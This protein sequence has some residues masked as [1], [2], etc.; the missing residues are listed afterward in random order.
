M[1]VD[2]DVYKLSNADIYSSLCR[3]RI[4][5]GET[6]LIKNTPYNKY[7][8]CRFSFHICRAAEVCKKKVVKFL[9]ELQEVMFL[10][11]IF[12]FRE[13]DFNEKQI[14]GSQHSESR[15]MLWLPLAQI[16]PEVITKGTT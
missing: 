1:V 2:E 7:Q 6:K 3:T 10:W 4:L 8:F 12:S 11:I 9:C 16:F 15:D 13:N 5:G 14:L